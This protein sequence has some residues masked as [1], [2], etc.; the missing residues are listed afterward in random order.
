[1]KVF[2]EFRK[3]YDDI[4]W[5]QQRAILAARNEDVNNFN[6]EMLSY[7]PNKTRTYRSVDNTIDEDQLV[8]Y[9]TEFLNTLKIGAVIMTLRNLDIPKKY[10]MDLD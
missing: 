8:N 2:P 10:V 7:I 5:L 1:M 6:E 9:P 3:N 4:D